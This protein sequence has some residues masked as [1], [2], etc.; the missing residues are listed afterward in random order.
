MQK[1]QKSNNYETIQKYEVK[2]AMNHKKEY[3]NQNQHQ[4]YVYNEI[5]KISFENSK[6]DLFRLVFLEI[7]LI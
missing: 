3:Q 2:F 7:T 6:I 1:S 4:F 5:R